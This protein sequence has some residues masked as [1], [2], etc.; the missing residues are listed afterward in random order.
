MY[1]QSI[2]PYVVL[3]F[4]LVVIDQ[5]TKMRLIDFF[6]SENDQVIHIF[7]GLNLLS[8]WN[9]GISF[10]LFSELEYSNIVFLVLSS[11][12]V[13]ILIILLFKEKTKL[14]SLSYAFIIGG[15]L[16]NI[17][18]R[19]NYDAVFDFIDIYVGQYHWP[20]F[21]M[22]DSYICFGAMLLIFSS[23]KTRY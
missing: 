20:A 19:L 12:A 1:K 13:L 8:A 14:Y 11:I 17:I 15:A 10:G 6:A 22:A 23:F 3:V 21:N 16:G 18:D 9:D 4:F 7:P 5:F 2:K